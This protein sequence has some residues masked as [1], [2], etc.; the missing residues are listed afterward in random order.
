MSAGFRRSFAAVISPVSDRFRA[1]KTAPMMAH[2]FS[3]SP[4]NRHAGFTP[5]H[6]VSGMEFTLLGGVERAKPGQSAN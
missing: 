4:F 6:S 1:I 3:L 5:S 2:R